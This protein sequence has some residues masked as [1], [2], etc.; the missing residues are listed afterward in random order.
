MSDDRGQPQPPTADTTSPNATLAL[1]QSQLQLHHDVLDALPMQLVVYE[2]VSR[3]EI[4][5]IMANQSL[6]DMSGFAAA[7]LIG[8][9]PS[10]F[11]P[12]DEA[13]RA[14]Q[15]VQE[16]VDG[17]GTLETIVE[18]ALPHGHR[19]LQC[20]CIPLRDSQGHITR[21]AIMM[22][23]VTAQKAQEQAE[24]QRQEEII[25]QQQATLAELSTP[26]LTISDTTV[27][28]PLVGSI[29]S[30][31]V[32]QFME[33]LLTG[34]ST[35]RASTVILDITGVIIVDT[36]VANAFIQASQ[37]VSLLGAQVVLTGIRPE[38]AQTLVGLGV[39]LRGII[40]RSTLRDG[41]NY[42]LQH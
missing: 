37:A 23:D 22:Q 38:V 30:R 1:L 27:V 42:A 25:G 8:K 15:T 2:I 18:V 7:E 3:D 9:R 28:M 29:D 11:F 16:C 20:A 6:L 32:T 21:A 35:S 31:R 19:W 41:I 14:L 12:A 40:T 4:R 39:D 34:V 26:L 17:G 13:A 24:R 33:T 10:E 36:Q 5:L